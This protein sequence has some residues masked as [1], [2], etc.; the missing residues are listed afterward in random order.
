M[1]HRSDYC[2]V[3]SQLICIQYANQLGGGRVH[4]HTKGYDKIKWFRHYSA[5]PKEK[6]NKIREECIGV[7]QTWQ[8]ASCSWNW[9]AAKMGKKNSKLKQ[10]TIDVLTRD[11]YC[12]F[13][14]L[15]L[16]RSFDLFGPYPVATIPFT[17][18]WFLY[19]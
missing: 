7:Q 9:N 12:K 5:G 18:S 10:E 15:A 3:Q 13:F 1:C 19:L 14:F 2:T 16:W 4:L 11:T 17:F 6:N 8:S